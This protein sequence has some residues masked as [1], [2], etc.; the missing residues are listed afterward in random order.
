M[1][2]YRLQT[3]LLAVG[4]G[5]G[6]GPVGPREMA[7]LQQLESYQVVWTAPG[8][9]PVDSMPL[10]NGDVALNVWTERD[11]DVAFYLAKTDAWS[12]DGELLKL[13]RVRLQLQPNPFAAGPGFTQALRLQD[14]SVVVRGGE[15]GVAAQV[16]LWVDAHHPT[17]HLQ[18]DSV[19][20]VRVRATPER[21]RADDRLQAAGPDRIVWY[22]RN[23]ASNFLARLRAHHLEGFE[24]QVAD[25]LL[26][27]TFGALLAGSDLRTTF[28]H[29]ALSLTTRSP[30]R[31]AHL[32]LTV[33]TATTPTA[34]DWM[35]Q[36]AALD[37]AGETLPLSRRWEEHARWWQDFWS[38]SWI[39]VNSP[40]NPAEGEKITQ[41]YI[42]QRFISACAGRGAYPIKFNGSL[43]TVDWPEPES[44]GKPDYR[45]WGPD[46]WHQNTRLI[47]WP[48]LASGDWDLMMPFFRLYLET[49]PLQ[50]ERTRRYFGHAGAYWPETMN[51]W[52]LG[53][54]EDYGVGEVRQ[55]RPISYHHNRYIR[56]HW[57]GALETAAMMLD[58]QAYG[59]PDDFLA[60][61]LLP[62][63]QE[64]LTFYD[65]HYPRDAQ[66]RIR[67]EPAQALE[68][69]W[70]CID[71]LPEIA[72]LHFVLGKLLALPEDQV[73][74]K[75]R[76][77]WQRLQAEL[78][79]IPRREVEGRL[80]LA[81][82][83]EF[84]THQNC[85][86]PEL[87]AIFPYRLYGIGKPDL[88][89]ARATFAARLHPMNW[90]WAQDE[91]QMAFLGLAEEARRALV[92]RASRHYTPARFPAFWGPNFDWIPDQ[93]HGG[94]LLMA[95]QTMLLQAEGET[96]LLFPA[97]PPDWE[98]DFRLWAPQR[99]RVEGR[100]RG[101]RLEELQVTPEHRRNQVQVYRP[102]VET[103]GPPSR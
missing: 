37:R 27:R 101:G 20:P 60:Q 46:Y 35:D 72:G 25:P 42:L 33:L 64:V 9:G 97:W 96:I 63:V 41:G 21:W 51:F 52:G 43:F 28:S 18:V 22:H 85:E 23:E 74:A 5:G 70:D 10:G 99:T 56:Y 49:L 36:L 95:L 11:G 92:D 48:M 80:L 26:H 57:Q 103:Q 73:P 2:S 44:R 82:A 68:T 8:T 76:S 66:G 3:I 30:V 54:D 40:G 83:R 81:P 100:Y 15:G 50:R 93:D 90:G 32:R 102:P 39:F 75:H 12:Q 31:S 29:G 91:T 78:P 14:A 6:I 89:M 61:M 94:N 4:W 71:P 69:W 19:R 24:E 65:Q 59:S 62:F 98:V 88:E 17:V 55:G 45:R 38:R 79:A 53:R 77:F 67:L 47:Y 86:N 1:G 13:G 16:R 84:A 58:Y 87:Y 34:S 7:V